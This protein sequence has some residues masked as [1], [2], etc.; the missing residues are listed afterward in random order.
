M[1][2]GSS[3]LEGSDRRPLALCPICWHKLQA[4]VGSDITERCRVR[5]LGSHASWH[6]TSSFLPFRSAAAVLSAPTA[7]P[8]R[9][10][11]LRRA[12]LPTPPGRADPGRVGSGGTGELEEPGPVA[13]VPAPPASCCPVKSPTALQ[14]PVLTNVSSTSS[15]LYHHPFPRPPGDKGVQEQ[16]VI[17]R[18]LWA[19]FW[20]PF[21]LG[22]LCLA[23]CVPV[24][25][26]GRPAGPWE[27]GPGPRLCELC[28]G[29]ITS[30]LRL[31]YNINGVHQ[32]DPFFNFLAG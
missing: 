28:L 24:P 22:A 27:R 19:G 9:C 25:W 26:W 29:A 30:R 18:M 20:P 6:P 23:G 2:Q 11:P 4:A 12:S 21:S 14:K 10:S 17:I 32:S 13:H 16:R 8:S 3:H 1:T 15:K 5:R 31:D 7:E